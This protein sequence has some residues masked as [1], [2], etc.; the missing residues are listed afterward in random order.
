MGHGSMGHGSSGAS[1][2]HAR[3]E[4]NGCHADAVLD[5]AW[6]VTYAWS[7]AYKCIIKGVS[8]LSEASSLLCCLVVLC[9]VALSN[10]VLSLPLNAH[11]YEARTEGD[12]CSKEGQLLCVHSEVCDTHLL[13]YSSEQ[14]TVL[15]SQ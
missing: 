1:Q 5:I 14:N 6:V 8:F 3:E 2:S 7:R 11:H 10:H 12:A 15:M 4:G 9:S 13:Q